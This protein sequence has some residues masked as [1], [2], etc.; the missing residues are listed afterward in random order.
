MVRKNIT[1]ATQQFA[2]EVENVEIAVPVP[3]EGSNLI[4]A[5]IKGTW[6]MY[7]GQE[8]YNFVDGKRFNI[9]KGLHDYL[10]K[11][12]NIYDTL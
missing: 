2:E 12:G 5:R 8:V 4:Q 1:T 7:W 10:R 6:Q 3:V 11:S 9:P